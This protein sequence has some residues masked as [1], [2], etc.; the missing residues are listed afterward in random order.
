[1]GLTDVFSTALSVLVVA[2]L[3]SAVGRLVP[4]LDIFILIDGI[5]RIWEGFGALRETPI[6]TGKSKRT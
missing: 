2:L 6:G 5:D 4:E 1:M 3:F